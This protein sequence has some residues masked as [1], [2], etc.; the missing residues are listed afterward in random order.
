M[1][2]LTRRDS[3]GQV[4][5]NTVSELEQYWSEWNHNIDPRRKSRVTSRSNH[6]KE[7]AIGSRQ[8]QCY[9]ACWR[10]G[11]SLEVGHT[12]NQESGSR[13]HP[14]KWAT[15]AGSMMGS[16]AQSMVMGTRGQT[17]SLARSGSSHL[18]RIIND[19]DPRH[20]RPWHEH[21]CI[22][23]TRTG[24]T[25]GDQASRI[26]AKGQKSIHRL[27]VQCWLS[28]SKSISL[29]LRFCLKGRVRSS[30]QAKSPGKTDTKIVDRE[31]SKIW[32]VEIVG[33]STML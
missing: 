2:R 25:G 1:A 18:A 10:K 32:C 7:M 6:I 27:N 17:S 13:W 9:R 24:K 23:T 26:K 8:N 14:E 28:F 33:H 11:V 15:S 19:Q 29:R 20:R 16:T 22:F 30:F 5:H 21:R 4:G 12:Q 31:K 3:V